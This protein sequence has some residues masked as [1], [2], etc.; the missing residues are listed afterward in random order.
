MQYFK[1]VLLLVKQLLAWFSTSAR[2]ASGLLA[3]VLQTLEETRDKLI[4]RANVAH[5]SG[6]LPRRF[7]LE[8]GALL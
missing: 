2:L 1:Q 7:C 5:C 6:G 3:S 8:G 4:E